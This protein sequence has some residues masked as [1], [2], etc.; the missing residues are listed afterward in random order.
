MRAVHRRH[1]K[2]S[3]SVQRKRGRGALF[4]P[5]AGR[6]ASACRA[7][8]ASARAFHTTF[9]CRAFRAIRFCFRR[10]AAFLPYFS[11]VQALLSMVN[12]EMA[13]RTE[14]GTVCASSSPGV[15]GF[16]SVMCPNHPEKAVPTLVKDIP[17]I[18]FAA[19][20][21]V[22]LAEGPPGTRGVPTPPVPACGVRPRFGIACDPSGTTG[23]ATSCF[24][25]MF[26]NYKPDLVESVHPLCQEVPLRGGMLRWEFTNTFRGSSLEELYPSQKKRWL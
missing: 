4:P 18:I 23:I 20:L 19:N 7:A 24:D 10:A 16:S 2:S 15:A 5:S 21:F 13:S 6:L 14:V 26:E 12:P 22:I 25:P 17:G 1:G 8:L 11:S 9:L 3:L